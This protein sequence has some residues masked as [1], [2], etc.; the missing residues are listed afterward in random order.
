MR[1]DEILALI[2]QVKAGALSRR[3]FI[4]KMFLLGITAPLAGQMLSASGVPSD[5]PKSDYKPTKRGGGGSLKTLF[6]QGPTLLNPHFAVGDKDQIG[7][8]V[9]MSR[10]QAGIPLGI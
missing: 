4:G 3:A 2:T 6:W 1:E 9:F 10:L 7:S 5:Q 8:R